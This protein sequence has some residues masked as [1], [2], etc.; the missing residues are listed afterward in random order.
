[1]EQAN[2]N[3]DIDIEKVEGDI[4]KN[5]NEINNLKLEL[6]KKEKELEIAKK[7]P[8]IKELFIANGGQEKAFDDVLGLNPNLLNS[9]DLSNDFSAIKK[10]KPYFFNSPN[11]GG[12]KKVNEEMKKDFST[13]SKTNEG[14]Y[15]N[16]LVRKQK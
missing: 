14:F 1:M 5:Q 12:E 4:D 10:D 2:D 8:K 13:S 11:A 3:N 7:T 16:S 6:E 9:N 15:G